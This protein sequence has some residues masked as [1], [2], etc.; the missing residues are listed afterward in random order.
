VRRGKNQ[1]VSPSTAVAEMKL[2][3]ALDTITAYPDDTIPR[4]S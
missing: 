4:M 2:F 3:V 1:F